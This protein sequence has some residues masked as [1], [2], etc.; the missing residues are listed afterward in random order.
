MY[1]QFFGFSEKPF[2]TLPDPRFFY[3]TS[4]HSDAWASLKDGIRNPSGFIS[5]TGEVGTGKTALIHFFLDGLD[6]KVKKALIFHPFVLFK[7]LLK[8][9]LVGLG[10]QVL[11]ESE[12][13]LLDLFGDYLKYNISADE[14]VVVIIDD[15]QKLSREAMKELLE[16]SKLASQ[17]SRRLQIIFVGQPQFEKELNSVDLRELNQ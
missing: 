14:T 11:V 1:T 7:D 3:F 17:A 13:E 12:K 2:E 5:I 9:I 10:Q 6:G 4:S 15:A 16:L 8:N